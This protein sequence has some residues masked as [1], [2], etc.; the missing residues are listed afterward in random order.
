MKRPQTFAAIALA[1]AALFLTPSFAS[2]HAQL[3]STSP[4]ANSILAT[5]PAK[6]T[7]TWGEKVDTNA[8]QILLADSTGKALPTHYLFSFDPKSSQST[9]TLT[10]IKTLLSGSYI[11]SWRAVSSDGHLVGGAY[12]FGVNQP[13]SKTSNS[14]LVSY[15][16]K[17]LQFIFWAL[18]VLAF[19]SVMAG[20][21]TIFIPTAFLIILVSGLRLLVIS[22]ILPNSYLQS[23][24]AKISF[25]AI[26]A[27]TILLAIST[28]AIFNPKRGDDSTRVTP[29]LLVRLLLIALVFTSQ[30]LFEGHALDLAHPAGLKFVA[31]GH[32]FFAIL[33]SGSVVALF[34]RRNREQYEITRKIST[35]SISFLIPL[36]VTLTW[37]LAMPFNFTTKTQWTLFLAIK[38]V[39]IVTTI[40]LG[41]W[42]HFAGRKLAESSTFELKRTLQIELG[43]IAAILIATVVLVSFTPPKFW[44]KIVKPFQRHLARR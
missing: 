28:K 22:S 18:L 19:G 5:P 33:W 31:A 35:I 37:F 2:A 12:S 14:S 4:A 13:P 21:F 3:I 34:L 16:D 11:V 41:A 39:F 36:A 8:Q 23:G 9:V 30:E 42:H 26:A 25:L 43:T 20:L 27:F 6:V 44:P 24:V 7:L 10:P 17:V 40:G 15:P 1:F 38:L 32:L 29:L